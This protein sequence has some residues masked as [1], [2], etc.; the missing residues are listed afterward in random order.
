MYNDAAEGHLANGELPGSLTGR[1]SIC[2]G[3][4][5]DAGDAS[6]NTAALQAQLR[7]A[8]E[9]YDA[10]LKLAYRPPKDCQDLLMSTLRGA[11]ERACAALLQEHADLGKTEQEN[12]RIL[13][14]RYVTESQ[15]PC[16]LMQS[17]QPS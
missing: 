8:Q 15:P 12:A 1:F 14:S 3:F 17:I 2:V 9:A 6:E 10:E 7:A 16:L 11:F 5:Q 13:N 4:K